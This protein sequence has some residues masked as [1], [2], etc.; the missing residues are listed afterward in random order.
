MRVF[1]T[2]VFRRWVRKEKID[3]DE[4]LEAVREIEDGLV[5]ADLGGHLLKK[6]IPRQGAGKSGGFRTILAYQEAERTIFLYGFAKNEKENIDK[7]DL[8]FPDHNG[9]CVKGV[10]YHRN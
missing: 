4:L 10:W 8:Q 3:E 2:K 6:R 1:Q 5:D 7:K 9:F